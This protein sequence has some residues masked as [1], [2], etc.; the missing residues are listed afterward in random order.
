MYITHANL[1]DLNRLMEIEQAGFTPAEAASKAAM[2]QRIN[3]IPD[4]FLVARDEK[5]VLGFVNGPV[6]TQRYLS[7]NLFATVNPNPQKGGF[8]S[9]LGLAV[10]PQFQQQHIASEL[11][12]QLAK[13]ALDRQRVGMT[14][15]CLARLVRFY[16][17][18]GY[19]DEGISSSTHGGEVWH[20]M[21]KIF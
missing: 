6:I 2:L 12:T 8:Q 1:V 9:I 5:Q 20:N 4:S 21:V 19:V 7:D 13:I 11:L 16:E 3:V 14:L 10:A 15:T 17:H 18:N